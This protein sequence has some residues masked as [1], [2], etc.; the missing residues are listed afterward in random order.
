MEARVRRNTRAD[1]PD[2][3][4]EVRIAIGPRPLEDPTPELAAPPSRH[5][6]ERDREVEQVG[7]R[8]ELPTFRL[9]EALLGRREQRIGDVTNRFLSRLVETTRDTPPGDP[10]LL[11]ATNL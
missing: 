3:D 8:L 4:P 11:P 9:L 1:P 6:F 2:R 10:E 5:A 7:L